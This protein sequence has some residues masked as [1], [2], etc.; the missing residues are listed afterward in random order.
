MIPTKFEYY[1]V[2]TLEEAFQAFSE[3]NSQGKNPMYYSGG[4][5]IITMARANNIHMGA[6]IDIKGISECCTIE[7]E[8]TKLNIGSAVTLSQISESKIFPLLGQT[9][10]RIADHTVQCK[11][12]I[13]GNLCGTIIY[14]ETSLPLMLCDS[15]V[16]IFGK[17]GRREVQFNQIFD[18]KLNLLPGEILV[19]IKIDGKYFSL[20]YVH[21]KKTKSDKIAYPLMTIAALKR[22][23]KIRIAFSGLYAYPFRNKEIENYIND[24]GINHKNK[25]SQIIGHVSSSILNDTEG[26]SEYRKFVLKNTLENT[27]K[28]L[29]EV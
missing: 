27:F 10:A 11:L 24:E 17:S 7:I 28:M 14:K 1:K 2:D 20:P 25:I 19:S 12:T 21:V 15:H 23:D 22:D 3:L 8:D 26:S 5:E 4:T 13:G 18:K 29:N 6:V 16:V 9:A